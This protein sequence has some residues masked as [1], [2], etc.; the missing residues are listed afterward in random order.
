VIELLGGDFAQAGYEIDSVRVDAGS[1]PPRILVV[2]DGDSALDLETI[3][4]LSR[5]A[6]DR[7]DT[8]P[9]IADSYVLEVSSPGV[10]RPL[11]AERHFRRAQGRKV[12]VALAD[13]TVVTGRIAGLDDGVLRLVVRPTGRAHWSVRE[14]PIDEVAKAVVQVEFSPPSPAELEL[15][16]RPP[17]NSGT[18]ARA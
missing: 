7:L 3:A 9:G 5:A 16:G 2:A 10:D 14:V 8:L 4:D 18:E 12:E 1:R 15:V 6:S 11:T 13:G 17:A